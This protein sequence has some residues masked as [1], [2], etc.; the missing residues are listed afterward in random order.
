[1]NV[2]EWVQARTV[3][4]SAARRGDD[5]FAQTP[6]PDPGAG[7]L[8]YAVSGDHA[9]G[10][11]AT[12]PLIQ[13]WNG[14]EWENEPLP[15][16]PSGLHGATLTA[17]DGPVAVGGGF[18]Q[19]T[20]SEVPLLLRRTEQGW[21]DDKAPDLGFPYVLTGVRDDLAVGHGFPGTVVLLWDGT[22]WRPVEVPGRP[23]K[24]LDV[25]ASGR[26]IW[27]C[28]ARDRDGLIL[29][30]D[31]RRWKEHH[32]KTGPVNCVTASHEVWAS[33]GRTL[34]RWTGR[35]WSS[36]RA[37][38]PINALTAT[39]NGLCA[40]GANTVAWFDGREWTVREQPGTWLG[41]DE[42]WLVGSA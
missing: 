26:E 37:P 19:F 12:G 10:A 32:T 8:L 21:V 38:F 9:V 36:S 42:S 5:G 30:F 33:S 40:A 6:L 27:A 3:R 13:R 35:R 34:L 2:G 20:E 4:G 39:S 16:L 14:L 17:I 18:S 7:F 28:G 24:L 15:W 22:H 29:H 41:A 1:M 11:T 23:V 25:A 31:G